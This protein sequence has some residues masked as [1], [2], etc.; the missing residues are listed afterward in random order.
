MAAH[1]NLPTT[2]VLVVSG[3]LTQSLVQA[4]SLTAMLTRVYQTNPDIQ[5]A[6]A[7]VR[8]SAELLPQARANWLPQ[9]DLIAT[10]GR[11]RIHQVTKDDVTNLHTTNDLNERLTDRSLELEL[12]LSLY[13]GGARSANL[14]SAE[15]Q[16]AAAVAELDQSVAETLFTATQAYATVML[17]REL[18]RL[19]DDIE[20]F[21]IRLAKE[22]DDLFE[23]RLITLT[24]RAQTQASLAATRAN[25]A[26][27]QGS[28]AQAESDYVAVSGAPPGSLPLRWDGLPAP[29]SGLA[30]AKKAA[31]Q[32]NPA[33]RAARFG[34]DAAA[35]DIQVAR[36]QL[37]PSIT[38]YSTLSRTWD[39]SRYTS[40][41][42]YT[43]FEREDDWSLSLQVQVPLFHGGE[44]YSRVREARANLSVAKNQARSTSMGMI[45]AVETAW[46]QLQSAWAQGKSTALEVSADRDALS[47]FERQLRD[48]TSTMKD[49]LDA[50]TELDEALEN[51]VSTQYQA[52]MAQAQL[53]ALM[54]RFTAQDLK[55]AA[56]QFDS[57][58]YIDSVRRKLFGTSLPSRP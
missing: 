51:Q 24:D 18:T 33:L 54:G 17:Y 41:T 28:L 40:A 5:T 25:K 38:A 56:S 37:L 19:N 44:N 29:P 26:A 35:A 46:A 13:E 55:L 14:S 11:S 30:E 10:E 34:T 22:S 23:N 48:G 39:N 4:E 50:R 12:S 9:M 6:I 8:R 47:G 52:F 32:A 53:L 49:L 16:V 20:R 31:R 58:G 27:I 3:L 45:N 1:R 36:G 15:S 7:E 57:Q 43:E 21:L 42:D 2:V